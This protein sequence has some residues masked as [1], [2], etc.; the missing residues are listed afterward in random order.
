M[1][2]KLSQV[3]SAITGF[4]SFSC[5]WEDPIDVTSVGLYQIDMTADGDGRPPA[6]ALDRYSTAAAGIAASAAA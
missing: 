1:V 5:G 4:R 3:T 2:S 6:A